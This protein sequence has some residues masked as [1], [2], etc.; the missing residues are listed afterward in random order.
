MLSRPVGLVAF[1]LDGTLVDSAPDLAYC[2]D[3]LLVRMGRAPAGEDQVRGWIGNGVRMLV[4]RALNGNFEAAE[5]PPELDR[6]VADFMDLY[7]DNLCERSHI[8]PGVAEGVRAVRH[9]GFHTACITNK[10]SRFTVPLLDALG[11]LPDIERVACG[12][13]FTHHKPHPEALLHTAEHFGVDPANCLMVGDSRNDVEAARNAGF[14]V[15]CVPYGYSGSARAD[16]LGADG[17]LASIAD[18]P[19]LLGSIR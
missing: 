13:Q 7:A 15:L 6:A 9:A 16:E 19:D 1:D 14:M 10:A 5:S 4:K 18:L 8:Y 2:V 11:L 3:T 12:D 17:V